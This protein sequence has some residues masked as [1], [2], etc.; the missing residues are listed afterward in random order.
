[1][2]NKGLTKVDL[3]FENIDAMRGYEKGL[4]DDK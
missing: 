4:R 2:K 1:M 3:I